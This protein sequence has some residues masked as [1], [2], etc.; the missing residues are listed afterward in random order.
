MPLTVPATNSRRGRPFEAQAYGPDQ[1]ADHPTCRLVGSGAIGVSTESPLSTTPS[2]AST[3]YTPTGQERGLGANSDQDPCC[4]YLRTD[5]ELEVRFPDPIAVRGARSTGT[6]DQQPKS[7]FVGSLEGLETPRH[8]GFVFSLWR[9][10]LFI[11][12]AIVADVRQNAEVQRMFSKMHEVWIGTV[13]NF[14]APFLSSVLFV[15]GTGILGRLIAMLLPGSWSVPVAVL[16]MA[17]PLGCLN[18]I[19]W[20]IQ[21]AARLPAYNQGLQP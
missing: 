9:H 5:S 19:V 3:T 2:I 10:L 4:Q 11:V 7:Q 6:W 18:P 15:L 16:V 12:H 21:R 8:N 13:E 20:R 14:L 17:Y 1:G